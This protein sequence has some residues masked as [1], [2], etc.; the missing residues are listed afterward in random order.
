MPR[1][2]GEREE[3]MSESKW[4]DWSKLPGPVKR[5]LNQAQTLADSF[6]HPRVTA[7]HIM[8]ALTHISPDEV[9]RVV[10]ASTVADVNLVIH[11]L[12]PEENLAG[13]DRV[14]RDAQSLS[15][16]GSVELN[17]LIKAAARGCGF[18]MRPAGA[19]APVTREDEDTRIFEFNAP[20]PEEEVIPAPPLSPFLS[21]FGRDLTELARQGKLHKII[22]RNGEIDLVVET[23]C[24]VFKRNPLL[25]GPAGVGKTAIVEGLAQRLAAGD[26]AAPLRGRRIL[27]LN[28]ATVLAGTK[29][30]GEFEERITHILAELRDSGVIL[31]IDEFHS[32]MGAGLTEGATLDASIMFLPALAR[33]E[34][35]C[36]GATTDA[37]YHRFVARNK[38][39]ERRFQPIRIAELS[40]EET[41]NMLKELVPVKFERPHGLRIDE[42][43]F[44]EVIGLSQRYMRNRYFPDKAIDILDHAVGRAVRTGSR[45]ITV[46]DI[47][48]QMGALTGLPIGKMEDEMRNKLQGLSAFLKSRILGQDHVVE[49]VVDVIW[50][51]IL[52]ADLHPERP[53]GVFLFIGPSGV[54]KTELAKALAEFLF[55]SPDKLIR[56][57]MSEF[58]EPHSVAKFL[59]APF[60]YVGSAEG[61][62]ILNE[63]E[64]KPFSI[65]LLDE[66]EKAHREI[67]KLFLQVFDSGV[68]TDTYRRHT[69]F[70]DVIIVMTSNIPVDKKKGVGFLTDEI[71]TGARSL[72]T[73]YF[74]AEFINRIDFV[75]VFNPITAEI[76][77][78]IVGRN[79]IPVV[80][81]KWRKKGFDLVFSDESIAWITKKGYSRKWGARNLERTADEMIG[82]ALARFLPQSNRGGGL[83]KVEIG[84]DGNALT[85]TK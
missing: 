63:L 29:Y 73:K 33:G 17:H 43:I 77:A 5:A 19:E 34:I 20:R 37:H 16:S 35:A 30:R 57:D 40:P 84:V 85:I 66:I 15:Q 50:P 44:S 38:A 76:A 46:Q 72:L 24:R 42:R 2:D 70:S 18:P 31:F 47:K 74:P 75:G 12:L 79:I 22:G 69:Y 67:H 60:G 55:G 59:G 56:I 4:P 80:Q 8:Y 45:E 62:P 52:A 3:S 83:V 6:K 32:I 58:S 10:L 9:L 64:E 71:D 49:M 54:G 28:I 27:E 53:N 36:V 81:A 48:E 14:L 7:A 41:L 68:L 26:V 25:I 1:G 11:H 51:K 82:S 21:G 65:L 78:R 61:S 23:L 13:M 39:L